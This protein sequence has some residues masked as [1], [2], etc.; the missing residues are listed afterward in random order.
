[1]HPGAVGVGEVGSVSCAGAGAGGV[2][3]VGVTSSAVSSCC[4]VTAGVA[5]SSGVLPSVAVLKPRSIRALSA[6]GGI[7]RRRRRLTL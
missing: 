4:S 2:S 3:R 7:R 1:V 5:G 6:A